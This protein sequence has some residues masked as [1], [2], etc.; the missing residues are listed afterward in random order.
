MAAPGRRPGP[1]PRAGRGGARLSPPPGGDG[2]RDQP[3][4]RAVSTE[5]QFAQ[6]FEPVTATVEEVNG[7][8]TR[9]SNSFDAPEAVTVSAGTVEKVG[10]GTSYTFPAHS[11]TVLTFPAGRD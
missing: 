1:V 6:P 9:A 10:P 4:P 3:R 11:L 2:Q 7:D 8:S 5:L